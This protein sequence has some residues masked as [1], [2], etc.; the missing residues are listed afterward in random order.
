[1][2]KLKLDTKVESLNE[3]FGLKDKRAKELFKEYKKIRDEMI[4][5]EEAGNLEGDVVGAIIKEAIETLPKTNHELV[6]LTVMAGFNFGE[7]HGKS[8]VEDAMEQ[9]VK[10]VIKPHVKKAMKE[11][12]KDK[13]LL[14]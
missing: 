6:Y 10:Q 3:M 4:D 9:M 13:S 5:E 14:N 7:H 12:S 1:M 11:K 2:I 8:K